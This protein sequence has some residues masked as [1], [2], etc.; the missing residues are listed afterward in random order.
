MAIIIILIAT[1][2]RLSLCQGEEEEQSSTILYENREVVS[3]SQGE[4]H[5]YR[6][7]SSGVG[8]GVQNNVKINIETN[9][10]HS[11]EDKVLSSLG[12]HQQ[13]KGQRQRLNKHGNDSDNKNRSAVSLLHV[14][15]AVLVCVS[16]CDWTA[17]NRL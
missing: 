15:G 4:Q 8:G 13:Q 1:T 5:E 9:V 7:F 12:V 10:H 6:S 14:H 3:Q 17:I 16:L 11:N 2:P